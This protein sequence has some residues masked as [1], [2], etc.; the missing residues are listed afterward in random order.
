MSAD[1]RICLMEWDHGTAWYG[2]HGSC[3]MSYFEPP[4]SANWFRRYEEALD[5]AANEAK[6]MVILEGG[7]TVVGVDEQKQ[8]LKEI[9]EDCLKRADNIEKWGV[10][11]PV[12]NDLNVS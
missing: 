1:N 12:N 9:A 10:Q 2:W 5:W 6:D 11:Y 3:S 8:A 7:I 4:A